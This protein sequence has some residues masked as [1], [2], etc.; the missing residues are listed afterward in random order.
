MRCGGLYSKGF[1][2]FV[3]FLFAS[4]DFFTVCG[5]VFGSLHVFFA[6]GSSDEVPAFRFLVK[7]NGVLV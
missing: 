5:F 7:M 2:D 4:G 6:S 3:L 1:L